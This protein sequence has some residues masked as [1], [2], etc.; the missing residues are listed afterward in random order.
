VGST[1]EITRGVLYLAKTGMPNYP[2]H[3]LPLGRGFIGNVRNVTVQK[4]RILL[5]RFWWPM[6]SYSGG[7][8]QED[9]GLRPAQG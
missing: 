2:C 9:R 1:A 8:D 6:P 7:K 4:I 3:T 5:A